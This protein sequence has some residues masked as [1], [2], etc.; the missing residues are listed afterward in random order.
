MSDDRNYF[1]HRISHEGDIARQLLADG[2]LSIG[3]R[4]A[5]DSGDAAFAKTGHADAYA[6]FEKALEALFRRR[7]RSR[8]VLYRFLT[9]MTV[10]DLVVVPA[11]SS[12]GVY[13]VKGE[14]IPR[15]DFPPEVTTIVGD[16]DIGFVLPVAP[17]A[18]GGTEIGKE[19]AGDALVRKLNYRGAGLDITAVGPEVQHALARFRENAPLV[20]TDDLVEALTASALDRLRKT[21]TPAQFE[22]LL[23]DYFERLGATDVTIPSKRDKHGRE[24]K[25]GDVDVVAR[26]EPLRTVFYVQAKKHEGTTGK[27]AV[28]QIDAFASGQADLGEADEYAVVKWAVTTGDEFGAEAVALAQERG[29]VLVTGSEFVRMLLQV[30][31]GFS[32]G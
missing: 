11:G 1:M 12:F 8:R 2:Y 22:E 17:A 27:W 5:G 10:G 7:F 31:V 4:L 26:F 20:V 24:E 29:V 32:R 23:S 6:A 19:Y 25:E 13:E 15:K 30:G 3:Y 21:V 18:A 9:E 16:R 28:E 14:P